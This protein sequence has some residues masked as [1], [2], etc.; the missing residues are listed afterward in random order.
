MFVV[1]PTLPLI[2]LSTSCFVS[3]RCCV[4][5]VDGDKVDL[6]LRASRTGNQMEQVEGEADTPSDPE[7][8]SL[9]DLTEGGVV[10]GYVKAVTNVGVFVR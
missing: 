9:E 6:S 8:A 3:F 7:I 5:A 1:E 4:V 2:R 10:R